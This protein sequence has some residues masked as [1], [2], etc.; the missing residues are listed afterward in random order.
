[1]KHLELGMG[2]IKLRCWPKGSHWISQITWDIAKTK[3]PLFKLIARPYFRKDNCTTHW[4]WR[5]KFVISM[6]CRRKIYNFIKGECLKCYFSYFQPPYFF[7]HLNRTVFLLFMKLSALN[8]KVHICWK[9]SALSDISENS[10]D[11]VNYYTLLCTTWILYLK[12][13]KIPI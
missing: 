7:Y 8:K 1:M 12:S 9:V 5:I 4:A 13:I 3:V 11:L 6:Y 10:E 2:Y